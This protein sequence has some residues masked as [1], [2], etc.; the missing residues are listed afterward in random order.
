MALNLSVFSKE[1]YFHVSFHSMFTHQVPVKILCHSPHTVGHCE[2]SHGCQDTNYRICIVCGLIG[3]WPWKSGREQALIPS[4]QFMNHIK[5]SNSFGTK[6]VHRGICLVNICQISQLDILECMYL[7]VLSD[8]SDLRHTI[9]SLLPLKFQETD[10]H[11]YIHESSWKESFVE[12]F[13]YVING[14][15]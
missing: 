2:L 13:L 14:S 11:A 10:L 12:M 7:C 1:E 4:R 6:K 15:Y 5:D 9:D 3:P 8:I